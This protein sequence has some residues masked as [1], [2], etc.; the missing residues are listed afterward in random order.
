MRCPRLNPDVVLLDMLLP[1]ILGE[2]VLDRLHAADVLMPI[3]N[4]TG[5]ADPALGRYVFGQGAFDYIA[6]PFNLTRHRLVLKAALAF[7]R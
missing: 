3:I 5:N 7:H 4:L 6:K 2:M 1:G